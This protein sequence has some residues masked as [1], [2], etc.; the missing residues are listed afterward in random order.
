MSRTIQTLISNWPRTRKFSQLFSP[1]SRI[2]HSLCP[3]FML[4]LVK[5]WQARLFL[6]FMQ[7]LET[8][9][10][11]A[12]SWSWEGFVSS[13]DVCNCLFPLNVQNAIQLFMA[14]LVIGFLIEKYATC[15]S[16][17]KSDFGWIAF[18]LYTHFPDCGLL[19]LYMFH[20]IILILLI[21]SSRFRNFNRCAACFQSNI[22]IAWRRVLKMPR[23][24][25]K[26]FLRLHI[27]IP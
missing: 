19:S 23:V 4:W 17:W 1:W 12:D 13:C 15:Q 7:H 5:I 25:I 8:C 14:G 26:R 18:K 20:R 10:L 21:V 9:L 2:G 16:H 3:I 11:I 22:N 24:N 27:P 6:K